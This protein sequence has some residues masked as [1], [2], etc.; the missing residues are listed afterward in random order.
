APRR[1]FRACYSVPFLL[2]KPGQPAELIVASTAG[3]TG[4][5]PN[6]GS[7]K[8]SYTWTFTGMA[9]RTV[10]SPVYGN[11]LIFAN[12]GDGSGARYTI[13]VKPGGNGDVTATNLA[14]EGKKNHLPYV[15]SML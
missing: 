14:W 1:P 10:A 3:I 5:D 6:T 8:W 7:E 4:Y 15:P 11:G 12:S 13:A 9:L 2:E